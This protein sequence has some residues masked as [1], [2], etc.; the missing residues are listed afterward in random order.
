[1][2]GQS[3]PP[4][5]ASADHARAIKSRV[6]SRGTAH[7]TCSR[8]AA[9]I[10][11]LIGRLGYYVA[12]DDRLFRQNVRDTFGEADRAAIIPRESSAESS[13]ENA[14][15]NEI[16]LAD[17]RAT[18]GSPFIISVIKIESTLAP[19]NRRTLFIAAIAR[20]NIARTCQCYYRSRD[21]ARTN[22]RNVS[23]NII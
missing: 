18:S 21:H 23:D 7:A 19:C 11:P 20:A 1:M 10:P 3:R 17:V 8:C 14:I 16:D 5:A 9:A 15:R 2:I 6:H 4:S 12:R 22:D 13:R